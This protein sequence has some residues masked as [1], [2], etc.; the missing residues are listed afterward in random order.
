MGGCRA[1]KLFA[2]SLLRLSV[3]PIG[4]PP[5][6]NGV[7]RYPSAWSTNYAEILRAQMGKSIDEGSG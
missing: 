7:R 3:F 1:G 5:R 4:L 6:A 2:R